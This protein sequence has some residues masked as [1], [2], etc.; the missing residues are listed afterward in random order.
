[1][2]ENLRHQ[3]ELLFSSYKDELSFIREQCHFYQLNLN[4][5]RKFKWIQLIQ[6]DYPCLIEKISTD[7]MIKI[8][9]IEQILL[10][11]LRNLNKQLLKNYIFK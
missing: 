4:E 5:E 8:P 7:F 9:Q 3:Y 6:I 11:M 2:L 1:M 10:Q